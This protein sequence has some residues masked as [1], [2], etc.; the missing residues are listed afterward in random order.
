[1]AVTVVAHA[2]HG[3]LD[4][5]GELT[6]DLPHLLRAALADPGDG[7]Y[8]NFPVCGALLLALGLADIARGSGAGVAMIALA[9]RFRFTRGFRPTMAPARA[10]RAAEEADGPAYLDAVS[11]YA[12]L[13][14]GDLRARAAAVLRD[15]DRVTVAGPS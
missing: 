10:A 5:V 3:K 8:S 11:R 2:H 15:R 13:A 1:M 12:G 6:E 7:A 14:A 9:H 4:L